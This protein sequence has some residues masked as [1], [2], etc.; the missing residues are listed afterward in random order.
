VLLVSLGTGLVA[1]F[2]FSAA[3]PLQRSGPEEL[4]YVPRG[5][6]L[7]AYANVRDVMTS[8]V[9]QRIRR[10]EALSESG[11]REFQTETGINIETDIDS[12]VA[13]LDPSVGGSAVPGAG[14]ALA[15]GRFDEVKIE[16]LIRQRGGRVEDYGGKRL[17][18]AGHL[19]MD[20]DQG[21]TGGG[22]DRPAAPPRGSQFALV[23][24]EPGL[25]AL[26]NTALVRT[27]ID[28][29]KGGDSVVKNDE[30]MSQ[31]RSIQDGNAWAVGRFDLLRSEVR[32]P[33]GVASQLPAITWFSVSSHIDGGISGVL[34]ADTR[35]DEAANN[36]RDVLRGFM[37]LAKMQAG[38]R[39][40]LQVMMQSLQLGGTGKTVA[41]SFDVPAQVLDTLGAVGRGDRRPDR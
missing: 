36:L 12:V 21:V 5:A 9:R 7:V 33:E 11:Q 14:M 30:L 37:A 40:E 24:L 15:R 1:Y 8:D 19:D 29:Q 2:G 28:L 26:G 4:R 6:A 32:L 13:C 17:L 34:R 31:V 18:V 35:D 22:T 10:S 38:S 41:L 25:F 3:A 20:R 39:P 23:F 16:S 27:A